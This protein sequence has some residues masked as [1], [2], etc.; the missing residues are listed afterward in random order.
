MSESTLN[1]VQA[2]LGAWQRKDVAAIAELLDADVHFVG[3]MMDVTGRD[4]VIASTDRIMSMLREFRVRHTFV[5]GDRAMFAYD[6]ICEP[7]IGTCRTAEMI[8]I[9]AGRIHAIELF[10]DARPFEQIARRS[11]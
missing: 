4:Q 1:I 6:F 11:P 3:P 8:E 10:Y 9:N 7:P 5:S 2:Y